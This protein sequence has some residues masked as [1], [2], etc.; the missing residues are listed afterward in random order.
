MRI[1]A[2]DVLCCFKDFA[3]RSPYFLYEHERKSAKINFIECFLLD[4]HLLDRRFY[5][6]I[7]NSNKGGIL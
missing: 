5:N 7:D 2:A 4:G 3:A 1:N 6:I